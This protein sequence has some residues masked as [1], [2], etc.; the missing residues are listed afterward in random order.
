MAAIS[1]QRIRVTRTLTEYRHD[2]YDN[3]VESGFQSG[4]HQ[5]LVFE[6]AIR[7]ACVNMHVGKL[8]IWF[9]VAGNRYELRRRLI[10][11]FLS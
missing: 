4:V 7:A 10:G 11:D 8:H 1:S 5:G 6:P 9:V 2:R 3:C